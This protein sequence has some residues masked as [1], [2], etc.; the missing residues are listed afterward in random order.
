MQI[1]EVVLQRLEEANL[2]LNF[3]KCFFLRPKLEYLGHVIDA[4]GIRPTEEKTQAIRDATNVTELRSFLGILNYYGKFLP[5]LSTKLYPLHTLLGKKTKWVWDKPQQ[6]AFQ[7]AKEALQANP[8][9]VHYD[10]SKPLILAC[11]ASQYGIGTV[12]SH[13]MD[14]GEER[15]IAYSSRTLNAAEKRYSQL[16]KEGLA[17]VSGVKFFHNYIYGRHFTI[18]SD[19]KPL[20]FLFHENKGIPQHASARV[21]RWALTLFYLPLFNL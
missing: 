17:I 2:R 15:P 6:D 16:E 18:Q 4:Q 11:D 7:M 5:N 13:I 8:L 12:L 1:L 3:G 10:P 19:H 9:L 20:S 21:Q 14:N